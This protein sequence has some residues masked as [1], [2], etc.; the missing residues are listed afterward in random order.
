MKLI[1]LGDSTPCSYQ[2]ETAQESRLWLMITRP[3]PTAGTPGQEGRHCSSR[4]SALFSRKVSEEELG[5]QR[6]R[7]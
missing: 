5:D 1:V 2:E 6:G 4:E 7:T 3:I